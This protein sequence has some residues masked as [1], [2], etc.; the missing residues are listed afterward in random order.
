MSMNIILSTY[1]YIYIY[2]YIR[3]NALQVTVGLAMNIIT[4]TYIHTYIYIY[5]YMHH[6]TSCK[7]GAR[8]GLPQKT[9][10]AIRSLCTVD[11]YGSLFIRVW[12]AKCA[13]MS[14]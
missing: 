12:D 4:Y 8:S 11:V 10:P 3:I 14:G 7:R 5:I 2:I 9:A 6:R 13:I 1:L